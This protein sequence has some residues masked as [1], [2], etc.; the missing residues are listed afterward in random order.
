MKNESVAILDVRSYETTF[1]VGSKG[2]NE[3]FVFMSRHTERYEG[4][5]S[6]GFFDVDSYRRAVVASV[7]SV[8]QN[9]EGKIDKVYVGVPASFVEVV[10]HGHTISF[11]KKRKISKVDVDALYE[12]GLSEIMKEGRCIRR[13]NMYFS[14]EDSHKYFAASDVYGVPTTLLKGALCYYFIDENFYQLTMDV[15]NDLGITQVTFFPSTLAQSL[16][17]LPEKR[18]EGYAFLLDVGFLTTSISVVYGNGIV[19]EESFDYGHG[20][21]IVALMQKL[22]VD[23]QTAEEILSTANVSG[24]NVSKSLTWTSEDGENS[25]SVQEINDIIK[26]GLDVLCESVEN[27]FAKHYKNKNMPALA[28]NPI[29][30]TGE[31][32]GIVTGA[33]EHIESRLNRLAEII[34]PDLPYYDKPVW[35]SRVAL[36][37]MAINDCKKQSWIQRLFNKFGGKKL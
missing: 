15:L 25:F 33:I 30:V 29:S 6:D 13:S 16:Y 23:Y 20:A 31:G 32:C 2:V 19:H 1:F 8:R 11:P 37:N 28:V 14:L 27:F 35:S 5:S 10:T 9:H 12:I 4:F 36:L 22:N 26:C 34:T 24:G 7:A 18:R 3:H 21:L 17:L